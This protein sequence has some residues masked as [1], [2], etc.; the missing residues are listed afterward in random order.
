[1]VG[2]KHKL[3]IIS[4][5]GVGHAHFDAL[6]DFDRVE[7]KGIFDID[8]NAMDVGRHRGLLAYFSFPTVQSLTNMLFC[9]KIKK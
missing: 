2:I 5:G 7:V 9:S 4:F 1:M 8:T 6:K 3:G